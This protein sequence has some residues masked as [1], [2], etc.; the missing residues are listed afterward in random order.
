MRTLLAIAVLG[1]ALVFAGCA[2]GSPASDLELHA[3]HVSPLCTDTRQVTSLVVHRD[4]IN[5][6]RFV[7][8]TTVRITTASSA[9]AVA[10]ALCS[11]PRAP[12]GARPCP[13]AYGPTYHLTFFDRGSVVSIDLASPT[14]CASVVE[15]SN[16][17]K[18]IDLSATDR[19][20]KELGAAIGV[21][22]ATQ[23]TFAGTLV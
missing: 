20:W 11:L 21:D 8:P 5:P 12:T 1:S 9:R 22:R 14:G 23:E 16:T 7:F 15:G 10:R 18:P 19:F 6:E 4:T 2:N 17:A 13:N 3:R